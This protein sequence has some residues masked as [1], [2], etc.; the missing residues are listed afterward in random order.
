MSRTYLKYAIKNKIY[1]A[2]AI[3]LGLTNTN[4]PHDVIVVSVNK[5]K[6]KCKVKTI[7]SLEKDIIDQYG[8]KRKAFMN[9]T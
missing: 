9:T 4:K 7:T 3:D 5:R 2:D 6:K 1:R 8:N